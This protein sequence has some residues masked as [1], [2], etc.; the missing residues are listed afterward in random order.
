MKPSLKRRLWHQVTGML[1]P[2][3][4]T[5]GIV[6]VVLYRASSF[7]PW[8][9]VHLLLLGALS[10]A[11]LVW[12]QH[13]ADSLLKNTAPGGRYWL[14]VRLTVH[15]VG[16]ALVMIGMTG[17]WLHVVLTGG[18]LVGLNAVVH[19]TILVRQLRGALPARFAPLVRY[20][21]A[22]AGCLVV[23]VTLGVLMA[24][25]G[26]TAAGDYYERLYIAHIGLNLLGWVGLTVIGTVALLLPTVLHSRVLS[27]TQA[28]SRATLPL[29]LAGLVVLGA[30]SYAD[31][32]IITAAG[33]LIYLVG[34]ARVGRELAGHLRSSPAV[35]Y[36]GWSV[37]AALAWFALCAVGFAVVVVT[38]VSWADAAAGLKA[39]V[40]YFAV[41]F[42]GQIMIGALSF[43][44]PVV[45]GG[46]PRAFKATAHELDR[47]G[48][49]RVSV[50]NGALILTLLP[51]LDLVTAGLWAVIL[52]TLA[53]FIVLMVRA[54]RLNRKTRTPPGAG[55]PPLVRDV[56]A[57]PPPKPHSR[58][59][60]LI[61]AVAVLALTLSVG[62]ALEPAGTTLTSGDTGHTTT[63]DITMIDTRFSPD[64]I[65]VPVG[66]TL[67]ITLTNA[68][69]MLH[70]L[71]FD[72]GV[73]SGSVEPHATTIV[74]VGIIDADLGGW[75]SLGGHRL[76]GMLLTVNA[77]GAESTAAADSNA[78]AVPSDASA[79]AAA[80]IDPTAV[81]GDDFVA[82]DARLA[83]AAS[84]TVHASTMT[85]SNTETEVAP[86]V[87]QMLWTYNGTAP[88][89][90]LR[91][92]VGDVFEVTFVNEGTIG[93]SLDFH[94]GS[95]A[96]DKPMQT[97]DPGEELTYRFTAT[98]SGIWMY[99]CSTMPMSVHIANG[100]FGAV[101]IDPPGLRAVEREYVLIQSEFYLGQQGE[102]GDP[103]KVQMQLPDLLTF[104]GYAN[105]YLAAPL[106][107]T[108][109]ETVRIWV[110]D[111]GP[112][113]NSSFHVVGGQFDTVFSE[114]EY[115]L[116]DGGS[117]GTGGAQTL[118]LA[119][120]QGGFVE[121]TFT[122]AG[123]YPFVSHVMSDAEKGAR[124][125]FV[126]AG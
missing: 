31:S 33:V 82:R 76:L 122:E 73:D 126:V 50:V 58:T 74:D 89:P 11:I 98:R 70:D 108:V 14:G 30:G 23:G 40:P 61:A 66:D 81:P 49:F 94:A 42:G 63:I 107:A 36:A 12:S 113:A 64:N 79:S 48:L 1:V 67:V 83:P 43:L 56:A 104:N 68:D 95:L 35:S 57:V 86:G 91:G 8:L 19:A 15:T 75:C 71:V 6:S 88:G 116:Q 84:A 100:M 3:W 27:T 115:L 24:H 13:F 92:T 114:G 118:A 80:D 39:L 22:S 28:A 54:L 111:A 103:V 117:T 25:P 124:G 125:L 96:P 18:I 41:G 102:E 51:V 46:G 9:M 55:L 59:G 10:T 37:S 109:G 78:D 97:I 5:L 4:L 105:Q 34:F 121:L 101:I 93:H 62:V 32:R 60:P 65:D 20:Y 120:A 26:S 29:L 52:T 45:L 110:L 106:T 53:A 90:T 72:N 21:I 2:A 47:A 99:H 87:T 77:I 16:A 38:A 112:N 85:V 44:I 17:V 119:P 7:G 123:N 69:T